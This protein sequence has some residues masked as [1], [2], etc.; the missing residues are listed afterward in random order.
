MPAFGAVT[1]YCTLKGQMAEQ[2]QIQCDG[3]TSRCI[4]GPCW[5]KIFAQTVFMSDAK[6]RFI[7][8]KTSAD[9]ELADQR[10]NYGE[11]VMIM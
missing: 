3:Q 1:L 10:A 6:I 5:V 4:Y 9:D 11:C 2:E 7:F 8:V